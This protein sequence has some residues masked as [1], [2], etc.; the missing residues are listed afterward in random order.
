MLC[1]R[2]RKWVSSSFENCA[3][4][5]NRHLE[6][7]LNNKCK[8]T[9]QWWYPEKAIILE[10]IICISIVLEVAIHVCIGIFICMYQCDCL[11]IFMT[12]FFCRVCQW[13]GSTVSLTLAQIP[14]AWLLRMAGHNVR[15]QDNAHWFYWP[16]KN[17]L[18]LILINYFSF[19]Y[20]NKRN[21][22]LLQCKP[23]RYCWGLLSCLQWVCGITAR[24]E[25]AGK[26]LYRSKRNENCFKEA[27]YMINQRV[28]SVP[29]A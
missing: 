19:F 16:T 23:T 2:R 9:A 7:E 3:C 10:P 13:R 11:N 5:C 14:I 24:Q 26:L 1:K 25:N 18:A 15:A 6:D 4:V 8:R 28:P 27:V 29:L 17:L 12:F 21:S 22:L 20:L